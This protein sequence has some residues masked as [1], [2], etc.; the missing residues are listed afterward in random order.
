MLWLMSPRVLLIDDDKDLARLL[1]AYLGR[2]GYE[3]D[4]A[5]RPSEGMKA[6]AARPDLV[7]LDV[8]LPERDGFDVCRSLREAHPSTPVIMLTARGDHADRVQ[9]LRIGADDYVPKP[10]DPLELL[11]RIEAVLRRSGPRVVSTPGEDGLDFDR[12]ALRLGGR[13]LPLTLSEFKILEAMTEAPG[14]L[15]RRDELLDLLDEAGASD[16]S[17]RAIDVHISRLRLKL[18]PDPRQ[19]RHLVTVRGLGYRFEW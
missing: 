13:E 16:A 10:F 17:D 15:F 1:K 3:L 18:E 14:K 12:K 6:L 8:M 2:H 19:P 7:L 9:G 4:W 5:D 11:A